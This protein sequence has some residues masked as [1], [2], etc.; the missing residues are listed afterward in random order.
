MV[1]RV[2]AYSRISPINDLDTRDG[3]GAI[4][5][6]A[7]AGRPVERNTE[8]P[9]KPHPRRRRRWGGRLFA[10]GGSLLLVSGLSLGVLVVEAAERSGALITADWALEQGRDVFCLP[11]SIESPLSRGCH[12]LIRDGFH[13]YAEPNKGAERTPGN[14][15]A[16]DVRLALVDR[17]GHLRLGQVG[18]GPGYFDAT[19]PDDVP[20]LEEKV[21]ALLRENP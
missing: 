2:T 6:D 3:S 17:K 4:I 8:N 19:K 13:L 16:H 18:S 5:H 9:L 20:R 14:E 21:W 12:R 1:G 11:G 7:R 10:L 15:V